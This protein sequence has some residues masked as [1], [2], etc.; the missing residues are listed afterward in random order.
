[1]EFLFALIILAILGVL[2]FIINRFNRK[3]ADDLIEEIKKFHKQK[4]H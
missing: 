1:M 2:G 3:K 4:H